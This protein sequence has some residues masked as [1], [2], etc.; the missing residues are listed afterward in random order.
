MVIKDGLANTCWNFCNKPI[1]LFTL[2]KIASIL[3]SNDNFESKFRPRCFWESALLTRILLKIILGWIFLVVFLLKTISWSCFVWPELKFL[4]HW[5]AHFLIF[6]RF[7]L[8]LLVV[9]SGTLAV[10]NSD[11]QSANNLELH[12]LS[13]KLGIKAYLIQNLG[14]HQQF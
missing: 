12:G 2:V 10:K 13:D 11:V 14:E 7:L 8:R 6:F 5:K 9:L 3:M 4:F 1:V